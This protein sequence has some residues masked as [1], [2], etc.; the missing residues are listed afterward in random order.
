MRIWGLLL[1]GCLFVA[2]GTYLAVQGKV[3]QG[4]IGVIFGS[5]GLLAAA[6]GLVRSNR[7][8]RAGR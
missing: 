8:D 1:L 7:R 3:A 6:V 5:I 4:A 2:V